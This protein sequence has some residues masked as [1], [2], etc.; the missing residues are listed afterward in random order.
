LQ[1]RQNTVLSFQ[2][3]FCIASIPSKN[4]SHCGRENAQMLLETIPEPKEKKIEENTSRPGQN[5]TP[6]EPR[7]Q[8]SGLRREP[9][10]PGHSR[11]AGADHPA[12]SARRR[13]AAGRGVAAKRFARGA[14]RIFSP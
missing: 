11:P 13:A 4:M 10:A 9:L 8:K 3:A 1:L 6:F 7:R 14:R 2:Q 5:R 12:T